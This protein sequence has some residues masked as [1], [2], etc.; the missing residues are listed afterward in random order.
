MTI[1]I[2]VL[3][4]KLRLNLIAY[5]ANVVLACGYACQGE[6]KQN[7]QAAVDSGADTIATVGLYT[8]SPSPATHYL[9]WRACGYNTYQLLDGGQS[10]PPEQREPYYQSFNTAIANAKA[11]ELKAGV[12]FLSNVD[13][14]PT[15]INYIPLRD[16]QKIQQ[17]LAEI[18][19]AVK[20]LHEADF[21]TFFG[22]DP[23]GSPDT[24]GAEGVSIWKN[25][26][27]QVGQ[28][29]KREAPEAFF[30][31][32]L[33]AVAHFDYLNISPFSVDFWEKEVHYSKLLLQDT[34]FLKS[35]DGVE[36]PLHNYYRSLALKAYHDAGKQP[37][38]YPTDAV[39]QQLEKKGIVRSWAWTYFLVDEIDDGYT[40]YSGIKKHPSQAETRYIH[41]VVSEARS[42]GVN[43]MI[44]NT[45]GDGTL[46]EALNIYAYARFCK[47]SNLTPEEVIDEFAGY[48]AADGESKVKL[49]QVI[50][51]IENHST[52]EQ[53]IPDV[54]RLPNLACHFT[55]V[56]EALNAIKEIIPIQ[57]T[58]FPIPEPATAYLARLKD[59][60]LDIKG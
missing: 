48:Y 54:Y 42:A 51:F 7:T 46:I 4:K 57:E 3:M 36:F 32:S 27:R 35:G 28:F 9:F 11:A 39:I 60:L 52:W 18:N 24:L 16:T 45:E 10:V 2:R 14:S 21:F 31:A 12:V 55:D 22:G 50:R 6:T 17:R 19:Y 37:E 15:T 30:N 8:F 26:A 25:M 38:R 5:W 20:S 53:S 47:N 29:V 58:V 33:W 13:Y 34:D 49:A 23:G 43:G 1:F 44:A 40:G 41:K 56:E 59:R